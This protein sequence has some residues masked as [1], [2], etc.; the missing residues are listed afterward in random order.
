MTYPVR[1]E[2]GHV[3][4]VDATLAGSTLICKCQREVT[5]PSLSRLKTAAGEKALS[6]EVRLEQMLNL[7]MLPREKNCLLCRRPT[8]DVTHF[9]ATLERA[10]VKKDPSR[11][12]W[13]LILGWLFLGWLFVLLILL[14]ARD[15]R[16]FGSDV[17]LR[18]PLRVCQ[19]CAPQLAESRTLFEAVVAVPEYDELLDKY[20]NAELGLDAARKGVDLSAPSGN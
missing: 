17:Q 2:C 4:H 9:W 10:F 8:A 1:C 18:L 11:V 6:P 14:R 16:V 12:W 5:I 13:I 19:D 20:P 7:G 15:D 3:H